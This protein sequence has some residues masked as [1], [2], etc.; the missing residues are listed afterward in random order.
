M[1]GIVLEDG[2]NVEK[3]LA[4]TIA[5][6]PIVAKTPVQIGGSGKAVGILFARTP[7]RSLNMPGVY[8]AVSCADYMWT[9]CF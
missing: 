4:K 6:Y 5:T 8:W 2:A 7:G 3:A 1:G 9:G